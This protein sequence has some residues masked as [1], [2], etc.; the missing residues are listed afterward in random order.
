MMMPMMIIIIIIMM[1]IFFSG[2]FEV[3]NKAYPIQTDAGQQL[4][5]CHFTGLG[6]CGPGPWT[7]VMKVDGS[8]VACYIENK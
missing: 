8:Q 2:T 7:M 4:V 6:D 5:Y 3:E 1:A